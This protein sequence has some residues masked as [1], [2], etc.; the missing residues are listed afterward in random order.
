MLTVTRTHLK[1]NYIRRNGLPF[2]DKGTVTEHWIRHGN[3]LTVV[4]IANDPVY[5]AEPFIRTTDYELNLNQQIPP[6]PCEAVEEIERPRGVIPH[7]LPGQNPD[8]EEFANKHEI[9]IEATR[10]GPETMYPDYR[11]KVS[12]KK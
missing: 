3:F 2:S 11:S 4:H 6:Y 7:W 9:P 12:P 1:E 10:G 5:L 8:L